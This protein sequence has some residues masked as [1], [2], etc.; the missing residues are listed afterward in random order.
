MELVKIE[1]IK[2]STF[3]YEGLLKIWNYTKT[4]NFGTN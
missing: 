3:T 2:T 1:T 4:E